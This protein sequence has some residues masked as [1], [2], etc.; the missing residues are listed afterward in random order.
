MAEVLHQTRVTEYSVL[1]R[2]AI[3][4]LSSQTLILQC[5]RINA[6]SK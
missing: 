3:I 6:N 5:A 2:T 4:V 1:K